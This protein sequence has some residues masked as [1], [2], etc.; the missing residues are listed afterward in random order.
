MYIITTLVDENL[1][2][3]VDL[4]HR[5]WNIELKG[6]RKIKTR[7]NMDHLF[8]KNNNAIRLIHCLIIIIFNLIELYFNVRTRKYKNINYDNLLEDYIFEMATTK[9][10][11][12]FE[13]G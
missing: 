9:I 3:I 1:E 4:M 6:F 7:Y 5:R 10:Y 2:F 13:F 12:L 11:K 8:I